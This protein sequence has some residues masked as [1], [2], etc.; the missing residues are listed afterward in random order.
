MSFQV[1]KISAQ[2]SVDFVDIESRQANLVKVVVTS[3]S[4][5]RLRGRERAVASAT[6]SA[7]FGDFFEGTE[8]VDAQ[9][10]SRCC[11]NG[12]LASAELANMLL[13]LG[14]MC[15]HGSV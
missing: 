2:E 5:R 1:G 13:N 14:G 3:H 4:I 7:I 6:A 11:R 8:V 12:A 9:P 10:A 15:L